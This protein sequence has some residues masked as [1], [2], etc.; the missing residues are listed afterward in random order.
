MASNAEWQDM[1][2]EIQGM[3]HDPQ[4]K[5]P[6]L[7]WK[8]L[9]SQK[10]RTRSSISPSDKAR[11]DESKL[12]IIGLYV[13]ADGL[14]WT[15]HAD[16]GL[17]AGDARYQSRGFPG[18]TPPQGIGDTSV[19]RWDP[20]LKKYI[21]HIKYSIGPDWRFPFAKIDNGK[22]ES[23]Y[24]ARAF[25]WSESD[26][27]IHWSPPRVYAY[28][29]NEDAKM[30]GMY[31]VYAADG[32]PYE[33]M[34]LSCIS[35]SANVPG[36]CSAEPRH[37]V[38]YKRNWIR[39]GAS[40][41]GRT[42]YYVGDREEFIPNGPNDKWDGHYLRMGEVMPGGPL[43]RDDELWF[44]YNANYGGIPG[45]P[46]LTLP[47]ENWTS[48]LGIGVLR[49]DGFASLN[50]GDKPGTVITRPL[51]FEGAGKLFVNADVKANGYLKISVLDENG[52]VLP[53]LGDAD[54]QPVSGDKTRSVIS[55][56][57]QPSLAAVKGKY[58]RLA[59]QV[60]NAKL[61]SFWIE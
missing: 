54:C 39:L 27:L 61:Y 22:L 50:A 56:Q 8:M 46:G 21:A 15:L 28:P 18:D 43:V 40:R 11:D 29:D 52:T 23:F 24:E 36:N 14:R 55:W 26:D 57:N 34:W 4:E 60:K 59:F 42:W 17:Q 12:S 32:F 41:D 31:G 35:M 5:N 44:Y 51:V 30:R 33:S 47:K 58:I 38:G 7:R 2:G 1:T 3:I 6:D 25:G 45:C 53:A 19:I 16:T 13:S 48:G 10:S 37:P 20:A 9:V 49:R